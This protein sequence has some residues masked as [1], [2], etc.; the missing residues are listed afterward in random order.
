[1]SPKSGLSATRPVASQINASSISSSNNP[2]PRSSAP[3][4]P[5]EGV[6]SNP[7]PPAGIMP[8][9]KQAAQ[10]VWPLNRD[11]SMDSSDSHTRSRDRSRC[12]GTDTE[13]ETEAETEAETDTETESELT[14]NSCISSS[15]TSRRESQKDQ[16]PFLYPMPSEFT[17]QLS[18]PSSGFT[19][20]RT[21]MFSHG[22][23]TP[24]FESLTSTP[25]GLSIASR[26]NA[27]SSI[28]SSGLTSLSWTNN[29]RH[30]H[31]RIPSNAIVGTPAEAT[32]DS[33]LPQVSPRRN[34]QRAPNAASSATQRITGIYTPNMPS[35]IV[36]SSQ[37]WAIHG[38]SSPLPSVTTPTLTSPRSSRTP[39]VSVTP[40]QLNGE[41]PLGPS[42]ISMRRQS[43]MA[44]RPA[45]WMTSRPGSPS[46]M[47]GSSLHRDST[48][49]RSPSV[50]VSPMMSMPSPAAHDPVLQDHIDVTDPTQSSPRQLSSSS[51]KMEAY[52]RADPIRN[53]GISPRNG[54][55]PLWQRRE[56]LPVRLPHLGHNDSSHTARNLTPDKTSPYQDEGK[57][58]SLLEEIYANRYASVAP[59]PFGTTDATNIMHRVTDA[60][61][62]LGYETPQRH[63][64][65]S[66]TRS[67]EHTY[68]PWPL[69]MPP[70]DGEEDLPAYLCTVHIE[71]Y[72]PRKMELSKPGEPAKTRGWDRWYFVLHG[73]S[74]HLFDTD[75]T[76]AYNEKDC[77]LASV[78]RLKRATHVH[79]EPLSEQEKAA[80][81]ST[82]ASSTSP[83]TSPPTQHTISQAIL[84][85]G[86]TWASSIAPSI[87]SPRDHD[88]HQLDPHPSIP[89]FESQLAQHHIRSYSLQNAECGYA[90]DY[91]KRKHVIRIRAEGEQLLIQTRNDLHLVEWIEALQ[92]AINVS[93]DLDARAMPNFMTLPR[94]RRR[95]RG[96]EAIALRVN[97]SSRDTSNTNRSPQSP[98][99]P[100]PM[101]V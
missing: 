34:E 45:L 22:A 96:S 4:E 73:T 37:E 31:Q 53:I 14:D 15:H 18:R 90:A 20:P 86:S 30:T 54:T 52:G 12:S 69:T 47:L 21:S 48:M 40:Q 83:S 41:A 17:E 60:L 95:R 70:K 72:L 38:A 51:F 68:E 63:P 92:A 3:S 27:A 77:S 49:G 10:W 89:T 78:W 94:R 80:A 7:R 50:F 71:G 93:T 43:S 98:I 100:P 64:L 33:Y 67:V 26:G 87:L 6:P 75:M 56:A 62:N 91:T 25:G 61:Q 42:A 16:H 101:M 65:Y 28:P 74:L 57:D 24:R 36:S 5:I 81:Q 84:R 88:A 46:S 39:S 99:Y 32:W 29:A 85:K 58:R 2:N 76:C 19:T 11:V 44:A 1:M 9:L 23:Q 35:P 55:M 13:T 82:D 66:A 97:R 8:T 79:T 59:T